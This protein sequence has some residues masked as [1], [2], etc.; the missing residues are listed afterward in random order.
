[1]NI[2]ASNIVLALPADMAWTLSDTVEELSRKPLKRA[3]ALFA[4]AI[5]RFDFGWQGEHPQ[6]R[7]R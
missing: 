2:P 7:W 5:S 3:P 6:I 1:V 4:L